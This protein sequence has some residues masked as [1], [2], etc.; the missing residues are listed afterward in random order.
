MLDD[1]RISSDR[2]PMKG[3]RFLMAL[4]AALAAMAASRTSAQLV[5]DGATK[6]INA[7][8]TNLTG[9]VVVGTN[10][11]FTTLIITNTG[12]V[13][14]TGNGTVGL[15]AGARTN[16]VIVSDAASAWR[17]GGNL[18]LGSFG[19]VST[20]VVTNGGK[21]VDNQGNIALNNGSSNNSAVVTGAGS[22]W[23]NNGNL[24]IG[25]A[26]PFNQLVVSNGAVA[27]C[28]GSFSVGNSGASNQLM[29]L[30]GGVIA[31]NNGR[32]GVF[33]LSDG[34]LA[35]VSG[36]GSL[37]TNRGEVDVGQGGS[38]NQLFVTNGGK[39]ASVGAYIG[40]NA[41]QSGSGNGNVVILTGAGSAWTNTDHFG[42]GN[43]GS[44]NQL[45]ITNGAVMRNTRSGGNLFI[46]TQPGSSSNT[47][48]VSGTNSR[49]SSAAGSL[50]LGQVGSFNQINLR[51]GGRFENGPARIGGSGSNNLALVADAG[52]VWTNSGD[53]FVGDSGSFNQLIVTNS[54][55][56]VVS[57]NFYLGFNPSATSNSTT[58][59]GGSLL[60][61]SSGHGAA[62]VR[63][64]TLTL[65]AGLLSTS[66]L[67]LT[68]GAQGVLAFNG[69]R[70]QTASTVVSNGS[71]LVVGDATSSATLE[72]TGNG[73]HTF[74]SGLT[75]RSNA[76]LVGNGT[77]TGTLTIQ[78]GGALLPGGS[79][80]QLLLSNAPV[81]QGQTLMEISKSGSLL[82]NDQL[83]VS[84]PLTYGGTL[85]VTNIGPGTL[86]L[87]DQ[88]PLF[89]ASSFGGSFVAA[90]LP[91]LGT[92]LAWSNK[93]TLNGAILVVSQPPLLFG[94][95][96]RSGASLVV[97][98]VGGQAN[99]TYWVLTTT[100]VALPLMNWAHL[101]TNQFDGFGNFAFT[102]A[103]LPAAPQ[104]FYRL[105][106]P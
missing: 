46:A 70:L 33:N 102:D 71:P 20:L 72:L 28:G 74:A 83:Q 56:V 48:V 11:S 95:V 66:Q 5:A 47:L 80:G 24:N 43:L 59:T 84:G 36:A 35:V 69:G 10:G 93:L 65:S 55:Q 31:N 40:A 63:R 8:T 19:S 4:A 49:F 104:R 92:G 30:S 21:V 17:M 64:G 105:Q 98:G 1:M 68:N 61:A 91:P 78:P 7:T 75:I 60:V 38:F 44:F 13:T 41:A 99:A 96:V 67:L 39:I 25:N 89:S 34:N 90:T 54:G 16:R 97:S 15:N 6:T 23:T 101:Q 26:G 103:I 12:V 32:L 106:L 73:V 62:D 57:S 50:E 94:S 76:A 87:G 88:F 42:L 27:A 45:V 52:S 79:I 37:W 86:G 85:T 53:L 18:A 2:R 81:L 29:L 100:N 77:V 82:T 9:D 14:N 3:V 58:L 22:L 51:N